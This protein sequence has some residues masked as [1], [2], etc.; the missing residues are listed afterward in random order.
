MSNESADTGVTTAARL[1]ASDALKA[2]KLGQY[3]GTG[4]LERARA[5]IGDL[6][7]YIF[8]LVIDNNELRDVNLRSEMANAAKQPKTQT[9]AQKALQ[10]QLD[11]AEAAK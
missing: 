2:I 1:A 9:K 5:V 11:D 6:A 10:K 4:G 3:N 7:G 8:N